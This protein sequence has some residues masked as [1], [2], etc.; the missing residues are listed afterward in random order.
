MQIRLLV[1]VLCLVGAQRPNLDARRHDVYIAGF[2]PFGRGVENSETGECVNV[3][4]PELS[5]FAPRPRRH[6]ERQ[7]RFGPRQRPLD[8]HQLPPS[9]VVERHDGEWRRRPCRR[10]RA[11][12]SGRQLRR[13]W[14]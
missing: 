10:R 2:F 7:T 3:P 1:C 12:G 9:H 11:T 6:A 14:G 13:I 5:T 4:F 8:P